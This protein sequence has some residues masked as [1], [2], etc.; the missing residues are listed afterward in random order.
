[1]KFNNLIPELSI[2]NIDDS[3]KF[4]IDILGFKKEYERKKNKFVFLSFQ[5]SQ[6]MLEEINNNWFVGNLEKPF[7]RG[8]NFQ[9]ETDNLELINTNLKKHNYPLFREIKENTYK[10]NEES[11]TQRELLVQD[12]DGYLLRFFQETK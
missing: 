2:T 11:I 10:V 4:Y 3:L 6:I 9:I 5:N 12:P 7:G 1:M 8:I